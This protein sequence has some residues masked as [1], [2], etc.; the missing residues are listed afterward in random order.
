MRE[1]TSDITTGLM[2]AFHFLSQQKYRKRPSKFEYQPV[3]SVVHASRCLSVDERS[4]VDRLLKQLS[5]LDP[6]V[7]SNNSK[8]Q[9][10]ISD[11]GK[12]QVNFIPV[13]RE[14]R[15]T[16]SKSYPYRSKKRGGQIQ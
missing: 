12:H 15:I 13:R 4:A 14:T 3:G 8:I 2:K 9:D 16:R 7:S 10:L 11:L 1:Q 6:S 5:Q